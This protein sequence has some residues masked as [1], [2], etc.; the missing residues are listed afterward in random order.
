MP[1][2][3]HFFLVCIVFRLFPLL[4]QLVPFSVFWCYLLHAHPHQ[5]R[6]GTSTETVA[7]LEYVGVQLITTPV[8]ESKWLI[9]SSYHS[10]TSPRPSVEIPLL[11]TEPS[12]PLADL[13]PYQ[14]ASEGDKQVSQ[15]LIMCKS[16]FQHAVRGTHKAY[17]QLCENIPDSGPR[18]LCETCK[19]DLPF[20]EHSVICLSRRC[21]GS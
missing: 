18:F 6:K 1:F 19:Q 7:F 10:L 14:G 3:C 5:K 15:E 17:S 2:A 11:L 13:S 16:H 9:S 20:S 21:R 4:Q 12:A 8:E